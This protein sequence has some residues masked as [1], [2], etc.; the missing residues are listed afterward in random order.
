MA[1]LPIGGDGSRQCLGR[2][3]VE[4]AIQIAKHAQGILTWRFGDQTSNVPLVSY[5]HDFF[6]VALDGVEHGTEVPR[7]IRDGQ[8]LHPTRLSD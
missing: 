2:L 7:D 5:E 3:I 8:C 4:R 1:A 6:L